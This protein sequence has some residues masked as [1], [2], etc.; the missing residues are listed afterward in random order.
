M[1]E[2]AVLDAKSLEE[3]ADSDVLKLRAMDG[4]VDAY[5]GTRALFD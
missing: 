2:A 4:C 1:T 5:G 3:T